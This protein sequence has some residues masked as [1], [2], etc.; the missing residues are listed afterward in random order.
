M[1]AE[2][3]GML[4]RDGRRKGSSKVLKMEGSW[5]FGVSSLPSKDQARSSSACLLS[6]WG[7]A[8]GEC[9]LVSVS[10]AEAVEADIRR[11]GKPRSGSGLC[12]RGK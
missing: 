5:T 1:D 9:L 3:G 8:E 10:G 11:W 4:G 6:G 7:E 12:E 2:S